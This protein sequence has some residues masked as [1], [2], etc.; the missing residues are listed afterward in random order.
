M[1]HP[2]RRLIRTLSVPEPKGKEGWLFAQ[3]ESS[4]VSVEIAMCSTV[5]ALT[6]DYVNIYIKLLLL[7]LILLSYCNEI[8]LQG[9]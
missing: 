9:R 1:I 8:P 5:A 7:S 3:P 2:Q 4:M 6:A